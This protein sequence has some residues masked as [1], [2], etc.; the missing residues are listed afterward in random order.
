MKLVVSGLSARDEV[1]LGMFLKQV[2]KRWE[3]VTAPARRGALPPADVYLID[4]VAWGLGQWSEKAQSDLLALLGG[5]PAVLLSSANERSWE[6]MDVR[7]A[8]QHGLTW[9]FKPY[10]SADMQRALEGAAALR[11][12][13]ESAPAAPPVRAGAEAVHPGAGAQTVAQAPNAP[14]VPEVIAPP[15]LAPV[16]EAD[17]PGMTIQ[18]LHAQLEGAPDGEQHVFLRKLSGM[19]QNAQPLEVRFT[20]QHLLVIHPEHGWV[21]SNTP[22]QVIEMVCR[23]KGI[24]SSVSMRHI[25]ADEAEDWAQRLHMP[26]VELEPFLLHLATATFGKAQQP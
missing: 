6:N 20:I 8:R 9:I 13:V 19:L 12:K 11:A 15:A 4:L 23:S 21:A 16:H 26:L 3:L 2:L 10:R 14:E 7:L 18:E 25:G 1:A 24:A 17:L 22:M 5:T